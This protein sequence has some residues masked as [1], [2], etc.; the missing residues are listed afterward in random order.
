MLDQTNNSSV[1]CP[2]C[3]EPMR[4]VEDVAAP[5]IISFIVAWLSL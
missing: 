1:R 3:N 4:P 2:K 5:R